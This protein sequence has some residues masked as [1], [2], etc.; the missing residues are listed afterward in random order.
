[1]TKRKC[2]SI[3][4][5]LIDMPFGVKLAEVNGDRVFCRRM[6]SMVAK[7]PA[8]C[9]CLSCPQPLGESIQSRNTHGGATTAS[10]YSAAVRL[11]HANGTLFF[12][13][14]FARANPCAT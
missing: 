5:S 4:N 11:R 8:K 14:P 13:I 9:Y 12:V 2:R 3:R 6:C 10:A 7:L 1:M